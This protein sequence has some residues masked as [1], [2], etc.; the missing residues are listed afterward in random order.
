LIKQVAEMIGIDESLIREELKSARSENR[1]PAA[2]RKSALR[3]ELKSSEKYLLKAVLEDETIAS[4]VLPDLAASGD[5]LGLQCEGLFQEMIS[6][7]REQGHLDLTQLQDHLKSEQD[8]YFLNQA[9]F[10]QLNPM[11]ALRCLEAIKRQKAEQEI[12]LLQRQIQ[13]AESSRDYERMASLH[14]RKTELK[15]MMA[16]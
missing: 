13:Q 9:L 11:E 14:T 3:V 8:K 15:K 4:R 2:I 7:Y 10:A 1:E 6:L 16:R 5:H 12:A